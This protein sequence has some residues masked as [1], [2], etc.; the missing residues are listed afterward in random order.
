[1]PD[2]CL[3]VLFNLLDQNIS[4]TVLYIYSKFVTS[5]PGTPGPLRLG[6]NASIVLIRFQKWSLR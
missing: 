6:I 1:M 2:N 3:D 5:D 4:V